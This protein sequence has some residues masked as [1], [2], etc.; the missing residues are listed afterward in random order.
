MNILFSAMVFTF[1]L[2]GAAPA[3]QAKDLDLSLSKEGKP[4][5]PRLTEE[6]WRLL[7]E[8]AKGALDNHSESTSHVWRNSQT[9]NAG[10][11]TILSTENNK[12][13]YCRNT[14]FITNTNELT[15]TAFVKLCKQGDQWV[16][17][18]D[19]AITTTSKKAANASSSI[20]F[21][22]PS[23]FVQ[24]YDATTSL[25]EGLERCEQLANDIKNLQGKPLRQTAARNYFEVECQ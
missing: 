17:A 5:L 13:N 18:S 9:S 19:R 12:N 10:V 3:T 16:E 6:D 4:A 24:R 25:S 11:I 14:R 22:D 21:I 20:M 23:A 7:K 1:L 8:T 15:T 2:M